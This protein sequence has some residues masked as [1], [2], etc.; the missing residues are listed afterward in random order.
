MIIWIDANSRSMRPAA[1]ITMPIRMNKGTA[2][3]W[4]FSI[5]E[6]VFRV[7]KS[8][9]SLKFDAQMPKKKAKKINVKEIGK[10]T[11][12]TK[13]I[14]ANMMKPIVGLERPGRAD[15]IS[16]NHSPPGVASGKKTAMTSQIKAIKYAGIALTK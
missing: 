16:V 8:V 9:V 15:M 13:I 2:I 11:K 12:I 5:V 14:A 4:S 6:F 3:S 7:I 1:S 10:P